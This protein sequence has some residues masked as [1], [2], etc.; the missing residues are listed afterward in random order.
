MITTT[1]GMMD[2]ATLTKKSGV[3]I[4]NED[5]TK[6]Y[7]EY[8]QGAELVHRSVNVNLKKPLNQILIEQGRL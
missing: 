8:Y 3:E 7:I 2:E 5:F 1:K 4:D 6:E